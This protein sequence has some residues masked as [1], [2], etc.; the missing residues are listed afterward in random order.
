MIDTLKQKM[1]WKIDSIIEKNPTWK[2]RELKTMRSKYIYKDISIEDITK[3]II[4]LKRIDDGWKEYYY[5]HLYQ[6]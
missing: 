2:T 3:D 4:Y 6:K 1:I 5:E